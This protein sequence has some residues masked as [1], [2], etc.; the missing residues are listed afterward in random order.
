MSWKE[1]TVMYQRLEF[2]ILAMQTDNF[3]ELCDR[4]DISRKTGYKYLNRYCE[5]GEAGLYDRSRRPK[6]SPKATSP[7]IEQL[8]LDLRD[9][10]S[11]WGPRKLKRRLEDLGH[12][13]IPAPSTISGILKRCERILPEASQEHKAWQRFEYEAPN[14]LW[15]M[16]FKGHF[17]AKEGACHPLTVLDDHSRYSLCVAAC[18]DEQKQTVEYQLKKVFRRYGLPWAML[19]DNGAPWG[20]DNEHPYTA[21]TVW[22]MR[23]GIRII[24]SGAY[25]PQTI[26]KDERFHRT[27]KAEVISDCI[28]RTIRQCQKR[29]DRWRVI[30][31]TQ[32][33]H[34]ALDMKVPATRYQ[35]SQR[36]FPEKL[37]EIEYGPSDEVRR[38]QDGGIIHF[39]NREFRVGKGFKGQRVAIR[40]TEDDGRFEVFFCHQNIALINLSS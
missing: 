13:G 33:P 31:N 1:V 25:H 39:Q 28:G 11:V 3:R 10:H 17:P 7:E 22:L 19:M 35:L 21:L 9:K 36:P 16:D 30:Y 14:D 37:P 40:P 5:E 15:Q 27:L 38:V 12:H 26:G 18:Q 23:L 24:H 6:S 8:I 32:R 2:V 4:F 34:E 29:F 20:Y